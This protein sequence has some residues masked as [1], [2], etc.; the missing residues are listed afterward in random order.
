MKIVVLQD[1]FVI[2]L[3]EYIIIKSVAFNRTL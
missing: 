2:A 1:T 3:I